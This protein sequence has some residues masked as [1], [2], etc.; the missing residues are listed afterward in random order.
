MLT[1]ER[2]I[3]LLR[4][5]SAYL[6]NEY[7]IRKIGLFGS[8]AS[9]H[10]GEQSDIDLLVEFDH[11]IGLRYMELGDYLE[12]LLGRKVDILTPTGVQEIRHK[13]VARRIHETVVY[14]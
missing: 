10:P 12:K 9:G 5:K 2:V 1:K 8:F 13:T 11:P 6:S 4:E 14:V 7:G 3:E